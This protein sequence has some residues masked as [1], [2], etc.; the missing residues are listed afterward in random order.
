VASNEQKFT[1]RFV[2]VNVE[3]DKDPHPSISF[4]QINSFSIFLHALASFTTRPC[5]LIQKLR[6]A[7]IGGSGYL[8]IDPVIRAVT[9][10]G[11]TNKVLQ[12]ICTADRLKTNGVKAELQARIVESMLAQFLSSQPCHSKWCFYDTREPGASLLM[13]TLQS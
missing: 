12:Q 9:K 6:M 10:G 8:D 5:L 4:L 7:S 13:L 11:Y 2:K 1:L 3:P